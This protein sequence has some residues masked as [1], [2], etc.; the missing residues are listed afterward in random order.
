MKIRNKLVIAFVIITL[1]VSLI[2]GIV[3]FVY[4]EKAISDRLDSQLHS[5]SVLKE[6]QINTFLEE[7]IKNVKESIHCILINGSKEHS[8]EELF[9]KISDDEDITELFLIDLNGKVIIST[10]YTQEGKLKSQR[11]YFIEGKEKTTIK[12]FYYA[13]A[14]KNPGITIA[15]PLK[16]NNGNTIMVIA[17][18]IDLEKISTIMNE[19][20]GLG[21]SGETYLVNN[22]N[23]LVSESRFIEGIEFKKTIHNNIIKDC[24]EGKSGFKEYHDYRN[25]M[26][27]GHY[28]LLKK[29]SVCLLVKLNYEEAFAPVRKLALTIL[30]IELIVIIIL[31]FVAI[32]FANSIAK[33][34]QNLKNAAIKV[35]SGK[36]NTKINQRYKDEIGDLAK[37]FSEM[38]ENLKKSEEKLKDY[39][40]NLK[41]KVE[42]RTKEL[43]TSKRRA[44]IKA[45][46][47]ERVKKAS[48][49][50]L[51]DVEE[52]REK[53]KQSYKKLKELDLLKTEF[54]SFASHELR[55]PLTPIETQLQRMLKKDLPK[56]ERIR[57]L[58][59]I[60]RNTLRLDKLI[61]DV[62]EISRIESRRMKINPKMENPKLVLN[63]VISTM[64]P[65]IKEKN[66]K[67]KTDFKNVP[68]K[69]RIDA[70]RFNQVFINLID[71]AIKHGRGSEINISAKKQNNMIEFCVK[72]NGKGIPKEEQTHLF[73]LFYVGREEMYI[74]KGAGL[75]LAICKGIVE[76]HGGKIW[77]KSKP[78]Q[79][80]T[81]YLTLPLK[82][83]IIIKKKNKHK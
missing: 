1:I 17:A 16:D 28:H 13:L 4:G 38:T 42:E 45:K 73:E 7:K 29:E 34:I 23:Y 51:E 65:L 80:T 82:N 70:Y 61:N 25:V 47:S 5:I 43:S 55:T 81:F 40:S 75:G 57:S 11:E 53:L 27:R 12:A 58:E 31:I 64:L 9:K 46:E 36:L 49:N 2:S 79:G 69:I 56:K 22:Y 15:T 18:R 33:P 6:A 41:K 78:D 48:L 44:E 3:S 32:L 24:L 74:H 26:V 59:M 30:I 21:E 62:L 20:S 50:I 10:D 72:D 19:R 71:N 39:S 83:K 52:A 68:L 63:Q 14:L 8:R 35:G 66:I 77:V 54:L 67:I 76:A 37:S 60:L